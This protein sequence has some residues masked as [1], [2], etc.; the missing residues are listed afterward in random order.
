[1]GQIEKEVLVEEEINLKNLKVNELSRVG[2]RGGLRTA[3]TLIRDFKIQNILTNESGIGSQ[4]K[5]SFMLL[6]GSYATV[7][8]REVM[9]PVDPITAGF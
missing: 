8:L 1:M 2:G 6:R 5:L 3:I 4:T 9:K 7:L